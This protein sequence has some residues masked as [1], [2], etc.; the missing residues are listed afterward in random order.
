MSSGKTYSLD[1]LRIYQVL[2]PAVKLEE[3]TLPNTES[4]DDKAIPMEY[5]SH[6][7]K[8]SEMYTY[9]PFVKI[10]NAYTVSPSNLTRFSIGCNSFLPTVEMVVADTNCELKSKYYPRDGSVINVYI[11]T[12][13]GDDTYK[14]LRLDFLMTDL[15]ELS[16]VPGTI[17][18]DEV[19]TYSISGILNVPEL[20]YR[21]NRYECGTSYE[22]LI[23]IAESLK[24]GFASNVESTE[25]SQVWLNGYSE[26]RDFIRSIA[27]HAYSDD[28]SFFT[29]FV[30]PY[31]NLNFVEV[32]RL[33]YNGGGDERCTV[34]NTAFHEFGRDPKENNAEEE[35]EGW[36]GVKREYDYELTNNIYVT[37]WSLFFDRHTV[38]AEASNSIDNGYTKYVQWWDYGERQFHSK[39]V[40]PYCYQTKGLMP[41]N[42]GRLINGEA[43]ELSQNLS[44]YVYQ[45]AVD[46]GESQTFRY[47][48]CNNEVNREDMKKFGLVVELPCIN[49]AVVRYSRIKVSVF[50][51]NEM[52]KASIIENQAL[53]DKGVIDAKNGGEVRLSEHPELQS[54]VT[55]RFDLSTEEGRKEAKD[56][57]IYSELQDEVLYD[58]FG[59]PSNVEDSILNE[60][61]SGY[62]VVTGYEIYLDEDSPTLRQRIHLS[63]REHKPALKSEYMDTSPKASGDSQSFG[64]GMETFGK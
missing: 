24:L 38:V 39:P 41:L 25:D 58:A 10:N 63:R 59:N 20:L 7:A 22:A 2:D 9:I 37:G 56:V 60:S 29:A 54:D 8:E 11:G 30:D 17:F 51:K 1:D 45:N 3:L 26:T 28:D 44:T 50:E 64:L 32:N 61:L 21:E 43:S 36:K 12:I 47:A 5:D 15:T 46:E 33:F 19:S 53:S 35:E 14:P 62:Y 55:P 48:Y 6:V 23:D 13:G 16:S 40:T 49:P 52:A 27:A 42:K 18:T 4:G 34:Y 57:G 31:Y